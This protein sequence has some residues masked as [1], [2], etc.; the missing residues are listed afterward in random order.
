[1]GDCL[2]WAIFLNYANNPILGQF[3]YRKG[4]VLI[5]RKNGLGHILGILFTKTS[6][7]PAPSTLLI[8]DWFIHLP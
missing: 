6:G 7:H 2:L 8:I 1:L 3:F 4:S 5:L